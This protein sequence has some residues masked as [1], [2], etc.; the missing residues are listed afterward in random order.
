MRRLGLEWTHRLACEPR[1]LF[2]RYLIND[3][4]FAIRLL[5]TSALSRFGRAPQLL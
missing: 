3:L 2:R 5:T 4:P 1:R